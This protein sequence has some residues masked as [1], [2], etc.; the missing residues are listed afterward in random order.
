MTVQHAI[1]VI[2]L[3]YLAS[4]AGLAIRDYRLGKVQVRRWWIVPW[5]GL[6][7]SDPIAGSIE[8][9]RDDAPMK[10]WFWTL[11]QTFVICCLAV[12]FIWLL[13]VQ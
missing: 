7:K 8:L 12:L 4:H 9:E 2:V 3:V 13:R 6:E 5:Y 10:F 1:G 11:F